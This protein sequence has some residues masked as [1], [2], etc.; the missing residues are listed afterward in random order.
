MDYTKTERVGIIG[1]GVA[2]LAT[3][4]QL[5]ARGIACTLFERGEKLGGVWTVGYAGFGAQV[6]KELYEFP[7]YPLPADTPD[8]PSGHVIQEYLEE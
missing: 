4:R 5:V 7:D 8:F 2:G 6:Q 1:A 3:A